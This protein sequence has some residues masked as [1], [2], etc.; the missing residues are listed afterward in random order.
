[1]NFPKDISNHMK[2]YIQIQENIHNKEQ[3]ILQ[4]TNPK[5]KKQN[6]NKNNAEKQYLKLYLKSKHIPSENNLA[7]NFESLKN[8]TT[9]SSSLVYSPEPSMSILP[10]PPG[11]TNKKSN[12]G[13]GSEPPSPTFSTPPSPTRFSNKTLNLFMPRMINNPDN[14]DKS[15]NPVSSYVGGNYSKYKPKIKKTLKINKINK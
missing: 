11:F 13:Y 3:N 9:P 6:F 15:R 2:Q 1:M 12:E 10:P 14:P 8:Q 5:H 7:F 4:S